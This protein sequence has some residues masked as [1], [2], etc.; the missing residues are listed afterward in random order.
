MEKTF[1]FIAI[2]IFLGIVYWKARGSILGA[3]DGRIERIRNELDE[4]RKLHEDARVLLAE[5]EK[6]RNAA[7]KDAEAIVAHAREEAERFTQQS[8]EALEAAQ[9]R[10]LAHT[11]ER[12]ALA[13]QAAVQ[14]VRAAA[15]EA[16]VTAAAQLIAAKLDDAAQAK[17]A[18]DAIAQVGGKLH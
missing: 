6:K 4:A 18:D 9:A 16:A 13:E 17:L 15:A 8:H 14:E 7:L 5:H 3:L 11:Q 2:L 12:I 1:I 10:R